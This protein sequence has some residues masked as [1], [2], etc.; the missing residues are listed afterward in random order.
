MD[1][2]AAVEFV[3]AVYVF[4]S[5]DCWDQ[6][7]QKEEQEDGFGFHSTKK[8]DGVALL[9]VF[10]KMMM[11]GEQLL[12]LLPLLIHECFNQKLLTASQIALDSDLAFHLEI[13]CIPPPPH[14]HHVGNDSNGGDLIVDSQSQVSLFLN[15][16]FL[17]VYLFYSVQ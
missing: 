16:M 9:L 17:F 6:F 5:T 3:Y 2:S 11:I 15:Y 12:L 13:V 10:L 1:I 7:Q 8:G 14:C 4:I